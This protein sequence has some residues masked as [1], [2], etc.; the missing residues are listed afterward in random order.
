MFHIKLTTFEQSQHSYFIDFLIDDLC[1]VIH[2]M[3]KFIF[4][5]LIDHVSCQKNET[6]SK[7]TKFRNFRLLEGFYSYLTLLYVTTIEASYVSISASSFVVA[8]TTLSLYTTLPVT[9]FTI[10]K[11]LT[12]SKHYNNLYRSL[13]W[14][15]K[16]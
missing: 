5:S 1:L 9:K 7:N 10:Q 2:E 16:N 6:I 3:P 8:T 14:C 4:S 11:L 12:P 13:S 15:N